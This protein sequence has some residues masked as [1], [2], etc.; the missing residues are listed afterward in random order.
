MPVFDF[1]CS[2]CGL[3]FEALV[4]KNEEAVHCLG[5]GKKD[6]GKA[7]SKKQDLKKN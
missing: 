2:A 5:C 4:K 3:I 7:S 6:S 1:Q